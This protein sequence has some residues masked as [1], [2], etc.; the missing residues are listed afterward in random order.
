MDAALADASVLES[1]APGLLSKAAAM[2]E[3]GPDRAASMCHDGNRGHA[4]CVCASAKAKHGVHPNWHGRVSDAAFVLESSI[5]RRARDAIRGVRHLKGVL[6]YAFDK[7]LR[8]AYAIDGY[9]NTGDRNPL[10][11]ICRGSDPC[12][13]QPDA[14]LNHCAD[15]DPLR[16]SLADFLVRR[17]VFDLLSGGG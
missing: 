4:Y 13:K 11:R 3:R 6:H 16:P 17:A 1:C 12:A 7:T 2:F 5:L 8:P 14:R 10:F 15:A 9:Y